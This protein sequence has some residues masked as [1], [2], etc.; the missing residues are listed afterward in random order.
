MHCLKYTLKREKVICTV[1]LSTTV[2][3]LTLYLAFTYG[4][5]CYHKILMAIFLMSSEICIL[6]LNPLLEAIM[7]EVI[8]VSVILELDKEKMCHRCCLHCT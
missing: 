3:R 7:Y 6:L 5:S 1:D 8:Y 2:K 4:P